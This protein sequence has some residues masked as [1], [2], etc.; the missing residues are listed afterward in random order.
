ME[1]VWSAVFSR[2]GK[3]V[4][5]SSRD[6]TARLWDTDTGKEIRKFAGHFD[7]V[8]NAAF[9]PDGKVRRHCKLR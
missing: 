6:C 8:T 1:T 3:L 2:D 9:S 5:T 4:L 7:D